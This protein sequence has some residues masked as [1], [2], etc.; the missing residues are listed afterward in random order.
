MTGPAKTWFNA[1]TGPDSMGETPKFLNTLCRL[2]DAFVSLTAATKAEQRFK[3]ISYFQTEGIAAFIQELRE[4]SR[5]NLI[6]V[7]ENSLQKCITEAIPYDTRKVITDYQGLSASKLSVVE[8][9]CAIK[10]V[11]RERLE[12]D[13][14]CGITGG[15][16][17]EFSGGW[18]FA[19]Q[20]N[21]EG[22]YPDSGN[23]DEEPEDEQSNGE[24]FEDKDAD[25]NYGDYDSNPDFEAEDE[26]NGK[27]LEENFEDADAG[28]DDRDYDDNLDN[29]LEDEQSIDKEYDYEYEHK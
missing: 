14:F 26:S 23:A 11:E 16:S 9:V 20:Y 4:T 12:R 15:F 21:D 24:D 17:D 19:A 7:T 18:G 28:A 2:A 29:E 27:D 5:Y 25:T 6:L 10:Q 13:P 8:W 3:Q 22:D 1:F